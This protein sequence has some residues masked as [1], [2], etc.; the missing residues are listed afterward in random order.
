[1]CSSKFG[2][3]FL[4]HI[5]QNNNFN[6]GAVMVCLKLASAWKW[7]IGRHTLDPSPTVAELPL[8]QSHH[9]ITQLPQLSQTEALTVTR[10]DL[11]ALEPLM[12]RFP[13]PLSVHSPQ[14]L[15]HKDRP[16]PE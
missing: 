2:K 8:L 6:T 12:L 15:Q 14:Q 11:E 1:M 16:L 9:Q 7:S 10:I 5:E 3:E 4:K 13:T